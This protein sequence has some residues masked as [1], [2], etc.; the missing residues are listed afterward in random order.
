MQDQPHLPVLSQGRWGVRRD[1]DVCAWDRVGGAWRFS[2]SA[3]MLLTRPQQPHADAYWDLPQAFNGVFE[4]AIQ[5]A[6]PSE[7]TRQRVINL[8]DQITYSVYVYT[9]QGLFERDKLIFLAQV[10]FQVIPAKV[11]GS[12]CTTGIHMACSLTLVLLWMLRASRSSQRG[13]GCCLAVTL[14]SQITGPGPQERSEP[15]RTGLSPALPFQGWCHVPCG[16]PAAPGLGC[17]QGGSVQSPTVPRQ[18]QHSPYL[19]QRVWDHLQGV[20]EGE[21]SPGVI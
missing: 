10:A 20:P 9:A 17:C 3:F 11:W 21:Q 4:K 7:D 1:R 13:C 6:V 12:C 18:C 5:R 16:L 19:E 2:V 15:S 8:T 14:N